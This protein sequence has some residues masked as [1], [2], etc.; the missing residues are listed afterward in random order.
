MISVERLRIEIDGRELLSD[1]SFAAGAGE[2][3]ALVG[4]NGAGKSTLLKVLAGDI[5]PDGGSVALAGRAPSAWRSRELARHRA[6]MAQDHAIAFSF[7]AREVVEMGRVPHDRS[8]ADDGI[9]DAAMASGDVVHLAGRDVMTLS[10]G[11]L[12]RTVFGRVL[13]QSTPVVLLDEPTAAL[14]LRHQEHLMRAAAALAA[15]GSCVVVVLHDLNLAARYAH[16]IAM[17][18][19]G[20]LVA[21]APPAEVLTAERVR[22]VYGQEVR[23][24]E[25]PTAG[26]PLVVA[27]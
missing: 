21:D 16:R 18:H 25:H 12:A 8:D 1:V 24:L 6:V 7:T 2:V 26:L 27:V 22:A 14:D 13:A 4:P 10:G 11:E 5:E 9:V 17:F 20:R 19:G 23:I 15:G 3:V